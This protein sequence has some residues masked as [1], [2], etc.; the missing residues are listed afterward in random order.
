LDPDLNIKFLPE[1]TG[2]IYNRFPIY[3]RV[4]IIQIIGG[5]CRNLKNKLNNIFIGFPTGK[6][7]PKT[8]ISS[9]LTKIVKL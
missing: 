1:Y 8:Q 2:F 3:R 6:T 5:F 7:N 9:F 4:R